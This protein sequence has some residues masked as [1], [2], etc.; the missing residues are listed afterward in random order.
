M[1][2]IPGIPTP[3]RTASAIVCASLLVLAVASERASATGITVNWLQVNSGMI[4]AIYSGTMPVASLAPYGAPITDSFVLNDRLY[5]GLGNANTFSIAVALSGSWTGSGSTVSVQNGVAGVTVSTSGDKFG[6]QYDSAGNNDA[7]FGPLGW[8]LGQP[9][10]GTM[11]FSAPTISLV[12][13]GATGFT[14]ASPLVVLRDQN[15]DPMVSYVPEPA[16]FGLAGVA[17]AVG[18]AAAR[19]RRL[20]RRRREPAA[21]A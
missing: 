8:T 19:W 1:T 9:I 11:T 6:Y 7:I 15:G 10:S 21:T 3:L 14:A 17:M 12:S 13:I 5:S 18:C 20:I 2:A 4:R 16:T